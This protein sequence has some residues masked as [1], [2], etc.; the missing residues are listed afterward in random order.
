[1]VSKTAGNIIRMVVEW[2]FNL[3]LCCI[4]VLAWCP[5]RPSCNTILM[6]FL[7]LDARSVTISKTA[8]VVVD[9]CTL[10]MRT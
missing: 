9:C 1:M 2:K 8:L 5:V 3:T 7:K 4:S 6:L 10:A